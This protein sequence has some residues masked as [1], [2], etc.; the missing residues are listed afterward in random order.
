MKILVT[1]T[2]FSKDKASKAKELLEKFADEIIYNPYGRPLT[3]SEVIPMLKGIDGYIAGLDYITAEVIEQAPASLKVISRYGA[4]YDRVDIGAAAQ[5]EIVVTNTPGVN[6]ESV[7][8][9][10]FG[11]MLSVARNISFLDH[12]V[13]KGN[14]P[15]T[16]GTELFRKKLG[17]L[18]LGAIGKGVALR[19]KGF[20]MEVLAYDP[21]IDKSFTQANSIM[22]CTF[23]E[24][25]I[26][27]DFISIH[28]PLN[29]QT[30]NIINASVIEKM[31]PGAIVVNTAR[32]GLIDE[33]AAY[34]A[35]KS[36][37]LGGLG[38]DAFDKEPPGDS[39]L[40]ELNNVVATPHSGAHTREGV[41]NMGVLAVQNLIDVLSGLECKFIINK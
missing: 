29:E 16:T 15:R 5:K 3:A 37:R 40:F 41:N 6:S 7:A 26:N 14:W 32:G 20:S 13:R 25:I 24:L 38:L 28:L 39:P 17:I 22:E 19:A 21:Y 33:K 4:G 10:A 23:N 31:K 34:E 18:G 35:L 1:P 9:L 30:S 11:L 12:E 8:D 2:S 36:G 27:S